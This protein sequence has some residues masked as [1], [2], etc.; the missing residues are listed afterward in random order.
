[1]ADYI[2]SYT[3]PQIDALLGK[4]DNLAISSPS[5]GQI[6]KYNS[7]TQK[8]ENA[9]EKTEL[10]ALTGSAGKVLAVNSGAT[11]VEWVTPSGGGATP[12]WEQNDNT[13]ADYIKHRTHSKEFVQSDNVGVILDDTFLFQ[14]SGSEHHYESYNILGNI[15]ANKYYTVT[16]GVNNT[17][18]VTKM[19]YCCKD[20]VFFY[21]TDNL[22]Y[23]TE[24]TYSK[25]YIGVFKHQSI[26]QTEIVFVDSA[27]NL[28]STDVNVTVTIKEC[29]FDV[30]L[31]DFINDGD[32]QVQVMTSEIQ[33]HIL[34]T[35]SNSVRLV[36]GNEY[37]ITIDGTSTVRETSKL[38]G[39]YTCV[40]N[41][42]LMNSLV[43]Q[44]LP[45]TGEDFL[46]VD[47]QEADDVYAVLPDTVNYASHATASDVSVFPYGKNVWQK[48]DSNY[49]NTGTLTI[50]Q[51]GNIVL[52][53][54]VIGD[55]KEVDLPIVTGITHNSIYLDSGTIVIFP[56]NKK[57][58]YY[59]N[60]NSDTAIN[61][62][63]NN[64]FDNI[65][66]IHNYGSSE[67]DIT[68]SSITYKS[69]TVS[70]VYMPEDGIT[71]PA[72]NICEIG[73]ICNSNGA[74]ITSRNDLTL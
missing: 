26:V 15:E 30:N 13:A 68:F 31:Y 58:S 1:M 6:L 45:D 34:V 70:N 52:Q 4:A 51:N 33:D 18:Y 37:K 10:P 54:T 43:G 50:K 40:G 48:L 41:Q 61:L 73:I 39:I 11:G 57:C 56:D 20:D 44:S 21:L 23:K 62:T 19:A 55:D 7:S 38:L 42:S 5:G 17:D 59:T 24:R 3:G 32:Y 9:N 53:A 64:D 69:S 27:Y 49:L 36:D 60:I 46:F 28:P 72:G 66:W 63:V 12:D 8:F 22:Q 2:S 47:L 16:I 14:Q 25:F 71:I 65:L 29:F 74:F 67:I 35:Y